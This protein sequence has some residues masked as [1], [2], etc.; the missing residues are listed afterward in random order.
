ME[1]GKLAEGK[2]VVSVIQHLPTE[3]IPQNSTRQSSTNAIQ[4]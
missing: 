3:L 1:E 2:N 4:N